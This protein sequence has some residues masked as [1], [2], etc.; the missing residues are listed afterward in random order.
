MMPTTGKELYE[1]YADENLN[2]GIG[3]DGWENLDLDDQTVWDSFAQ[4]L[5]EKAGA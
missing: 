1:I 3:V 5:L 2:L 4:N